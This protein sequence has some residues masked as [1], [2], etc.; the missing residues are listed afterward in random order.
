M[1]P[2]SVVRDPQRSQRRSVLIT[3]FS[4]R[5]PTV[6][7]FNLFDSTSVYGFSLNRA[8]ASFFI[9]SRVCLYGKVMR[10]FHQTEYSAHHSAMSS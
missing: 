6:Q 10:V 9:P 1:L 8:T 2:S 5:P 3:V 4:F 7:P